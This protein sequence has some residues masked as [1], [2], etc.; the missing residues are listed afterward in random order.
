MC[1]DRHGVHQEKRIYKLCGSRC[2]ALSSPCISTAPIRIWALFQDCR[3]PSVSWTMHME[4]HC[5]AADKLDE[6]IAGTQT[7]AVERVQHILRASALLCRMALACELSPPAST[8]LSTTGRCRV[9]VCMR[10]IMYVLVL[11]PITISIHFIAYG[12][13]IP[14]CT[15]KVS[16]VNPPQQP[17]HTTDRRP[18]SS[19]PAGLQTLHAGASTFGC[20]AYPPPIP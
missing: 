12:H 4:S 7:K 11:A 16:N 3:K 6:D 2:R 20:L 10:V 1:I 8:L 19:F 13:K 5:P 18:K 17:L 9:R 14:K 15:R